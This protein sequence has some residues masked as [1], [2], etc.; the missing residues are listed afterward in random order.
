MKEMN[1]IT[2]KN[3]L[4]LVFFIIMITSQVFAGT[5][6]YVDATTGN[7][8][9]AGTESLPWRTIQKAADTMV[10]GDTVLVKNG[11]Y[12]ERVSESTN[13]S[14]GQLIT[15]QVYYGHTVKVIGGF[16]LYGN[17]IKLDG[18]HVTGASP[19]DSENGVG[20]HVPGS[21]IEVVN[22]HAYE[23]KEGGLDTS[24]S[25][26]HCTIKN[27]KFYKNGG[28][29]AMIEG[30]NHLIE[31]N[32]IYDSRCAPCNGDADGFDV[33]G[34]GHTFKGNYIHDISYSNNPGYSPHIDAFQTWQDQY[35]A[36]IQ[37]SVFEQNWIELLVSLSGWEH[38]TG[39]MLEGGAKNITIKNNI[40]KACRGVQVGNGSGLKILNN[41]FIGDLSF[42]VNHNPAGIWV[43]SISN[44]TIKNNTICEQPWMAIYSSGCS[45]IDID[46]NSTYNSNE[47]I[48]GGNIQLHDLWAVNPKFV[49]LSGGNYHL[50]S[51]SPCIDVGATLPEVANDYDGNSR[52]QGP[53]YDIGAYEYKG[54]R[55]VAPV[56]SLTAYPTQGIPPLLVSFDA[57]ASYDPD[58]SITS[59]KWDFGDGSTGSGVT[60]NHTYQKSGVYTAKLTVTDNANRSASTTKVIT[61]GTPP[62][63]SF[64]A[65]PTAGRAPLT[66][67]FDASSSYDPDGTIVSY[68]WDFGDGSSG[69]GRIVPHIYTTEATRTATLSVKDNNGLEGKSSQEIKISFTAI[70]QFTANPRKG[71]VPL[72]VSFDA[73]ESEPS[74]VNGKI[75]S[76][77]WDFGDGTSDSGE[78]VTHTYTKT[79]RFTAS[80]K[81]TDDKAKTNSASTNIS[82]YSKPKALFS[83]SPTNG[84]APLPVTFDASASYDID[85]KIVSY[86]W[87]FGDG[88][89]GTGQKITHTYTKGG[90]L[91]I[92]L[93]VTDNDG[94]T[95]SL[96][97]TI[98]VFDKPF[99]PLNVKVTKMIDKSRFRSEAGYIIEWSK[100]PLNEGNF[101]VVKYRIYRKKENQDNTG[102]T[103]IAEI[104]SNIF[105]YEDSSLST[106]ENIK[107]YTYAVSSLDDKNIESVLSSPASYQNLNTIVYTEPNNNLKFGKG[108][109]VKGSH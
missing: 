103:L 78:K 69:S 40:V 92:V 43:D 37:N 15:Y 47:S 63:A 95:D 76:Y 28:R 17:Y 10:A 36:A 16:N 30:T 61:V 64:V 12:N 96:A 53:L 41:T 97:K 101:N 86:V 4:S 44:S 109:P 105:V 88:T 9:N 18:F 8:A 79:G 51:D 82:V 38:G 49:S 50:Q 84:I 104:N 24:R 85:G 80:L 11:T 13:G 19:C 71:E 3:F 65:S 73:S 29:G 70:A 59:Y 54:A 20:I 77:A 55:A 108:R 56:A 58:G 72:K 91:T 98:E 81:V 67:N 99:P 31:N 102:F 48:P 23:N 62:V 83:F 93:T 39:W 60:T 90:N 26:D 32:E 42:P 107:G 68:S 22:C 89:T 66:V 74:D 57:S 21:Y 5:V 46:Y 2:K 45:N 27:N 75:T 25:S 33:F 35:H 52:P 106:I 7:D 34:S 94:Y 14:Q 6:Y 87:S 100:N 1:V